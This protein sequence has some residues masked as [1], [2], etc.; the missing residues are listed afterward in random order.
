MQEDSWES[1]SRSLLTPTGCSNDDDV[2]AGEASSPIPTAINVSTPLRLLSG[3][4][5]RNANT[6]TNKAKG[7]YHSFFI[8]VVW[9]ATQACLSTLTTMK[10]PSRDHWTNQPWKTFS[11][12]LLWQ[13]IEPVWDL[14][15]SAN[16]TTEVSTCG[17]WPDTI[18]R[19]SC[20]RVTRCSWLNGKVFNTPMQ[21]HS[22]GWKPGFFAS[23]LVGLLTP[24][25]NLVMAECPELFNNQ[26]T[27]HDK[28][29]YR[30]EAKASQQCTCGD[31]LKTPGD[32][33]NH[34]QYLLWQCQ[35]NIIKILNTP[36]RFNI[37]C[38]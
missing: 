7:I 2:Y 21:E 6:F 18:E 27:S 17:R 33:F 1:I 24:N 25:Q 31:G 9:I 20:G 14:A 35:T 22:C 23:I 37:C 26:D 29:F 3:D 11:L 30:H 36:F 4:T 15:R 28:P 8:P 12:L 19:V 10:S 16:T 38:A 13:V 32:G 34:V 5:G